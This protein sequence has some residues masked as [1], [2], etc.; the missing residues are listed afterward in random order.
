MAVVRRHGYMIGAGKGTFAAAA[1][2]K[3]TAD[4]QA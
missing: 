1:R 3:P 2:V 4:G